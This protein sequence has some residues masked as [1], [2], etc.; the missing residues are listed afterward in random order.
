MTA[1]VIDPIDLPSALRFMSANQTG[2]LQLQVPFHPCP[3]FFVPPIPGKKIRAAAITNFAGNFF[4]LKIL[5]VR[6]EERCVRRWSKPPQSR[7]KN[8]RNT[9][10]RVQG[11]DGSRPCK[12]PVRLALPGERFHSKCIRPMGRFQD[13]CANSLAVQQRG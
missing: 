6:D 10:R 7:F 3:R 11:W 13:G 4:A 9:L 5:P 1:L 2:V 12:M 8:W